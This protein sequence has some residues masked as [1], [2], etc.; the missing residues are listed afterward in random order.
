MTKN[1]ANLE[2][3]LTPT[4][5]KGK[6]SLPEEATNELGLATA[7]LVDTLNN[8]SKQVFNMFCNGLSTLGQPIGEII[9]GKTAAIALANESIYMKLA[10]TKES[11]MRKLLAYTA[12]E[13][14]VKVN[15]GEEIPESLPQSDNIMLIQDNASTTSEDEFLQLWAK[16][17]AEEACKPNSISRK[18]IKTLESLD[19]GIIKILEKDIFPYCDDEGFFWGVDTKLQSL[20]LAQDYGIVD[21]K[22]I[23]RIGLNPKMMLNTKL[24]DTRYLYLYPAY[25]YAPDGRYLLTK[26]GLEMKKI[27]KIYPNEEQLKEMYKIIERSASTWYIANPYESTVHMKTMITDAQKFVICDSSSNIVFPLNQKYK[28]LNDFYNNALENMEFKQ[29]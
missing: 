14:D 3:E 1:N 28:T 21:T 7:R 23:V 22:N 26:A 6:V 2:I 4:S 11:N 12:E 13:L 25:S 18:T 8:S 16:L 9:K 24:N 5:Q 29:E 17:Y 20:V 15:S 27:L 10:V 19:S